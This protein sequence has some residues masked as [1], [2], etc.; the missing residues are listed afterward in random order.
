MDKNDLLK[1]ASNAETPV[2]LL[3][4]L[5]YPEQDEDV[6][7]RL[8][9]NANLPGAALTT[10]LR[11]VEN[12]RLRQLASKHPNVLE[13][14]L[15][16]NA[17]DVDERI[18]INTAAHARTPRETLAYLSTDVSPLVRYETLFNSSTPLK[19]RHRLSED[20]DLHVRIVA[21]NLRNAE[22]KAQEG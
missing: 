6:L 14:D 10:I 18:R 21:A 9:L 8:I 11:D 1:A 22:K 2:S 17:D 15:V 3:L 4:E 19:N 5:T 20:D 7:V 13:E 16:F 12:L